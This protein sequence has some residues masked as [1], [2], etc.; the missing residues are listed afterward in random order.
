MRLG[1]PAVSVRNIGGTI[2][3]T[4]SEGGRCRVSRLRGGDVEDVVS[5][6]GSPCVLLWGRGDEFLVSVGNSLYLVSGCETWLVL[7]GGVGN[8]FWHAVEG[9]N[10]VLFRSMVSRLRGFTSVR[11]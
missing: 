11:T 4:I 8:W 6:L 2:Y 5:M 3:V 7:R 1:V 10:L 9:D